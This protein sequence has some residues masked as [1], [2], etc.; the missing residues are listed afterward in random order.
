MADLVLVD[1]AEWLVNGVARTYGHV[2]ID[3]AQDLSAMELRAARPALPDPLDDRARRPGPGDR[4][5]RPARRGS[6]VIA[7]LG[8]PASARLEELELGY[9]VPAPVLDFANR[10][11]PEAAPDVRPSR[12]GAGG[13]AGT[14]RRRGPPRGPRARGRRRGGRPRG[15]L[16][17]NGRHRPAAVLDAVAQALDAAGLAWATAP[18][19]ASTSAVTLLPPAAAKG[20]EFD[21]V[22]VVEPA[23]VVA[24]EL[25][26]PRAPGSSTSP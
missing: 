9:R 25:D 21:S 12:L 19:S 10:L 8:S 16:D 2:V 11:L 20:L 26:R 17:V 6:E 23:L 15:D 18:G 4:P 13:R 22:V 14:N 24:D 5:R 3:E 7:H 1:E